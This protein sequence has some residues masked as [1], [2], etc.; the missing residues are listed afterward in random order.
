MIK[1]I[2][3][4]LGQREINKLESNLKKYETD[5]KVHN[6]KKDRGRVKN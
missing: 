2:Y 3:W 1:F 5:R 4:L 6:N